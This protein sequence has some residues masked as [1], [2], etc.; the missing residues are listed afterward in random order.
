MAENKQVK[1]TERWE[2]DKAPTFTPPTKKTP[3]KPTKKSK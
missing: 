2:Q 3:K 1:I